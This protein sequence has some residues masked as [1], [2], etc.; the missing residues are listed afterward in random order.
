MNSLVR[1]HLPATFFTDYQALR[2]ELI[3]TL[4]DDDL[5]FRPGPGAMTLGELCREIGEIEHTYVESLRTFKQD[6][7]Y[8]NA[9]P[10]LEHS[11]DALRTWYASLDH[12]LM[13]AIEALSED[14][15]EHRRIVRS[16]FDE[17][18]F[19]PLARQQLDIY[20]EAL[21]IFYGKVSVYLKALGRSR[22]ETWRDW[23]G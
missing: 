10:R 23:I 13:T 3:A 1:D 4:R 21:L 22:T 8:R 12:D 2:G 9:D 7:G 5:A 14:D 19:A 17:S 11:V 16:D 15:I 20:R 18:F 6:F